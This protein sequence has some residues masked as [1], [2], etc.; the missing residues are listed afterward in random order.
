M[1]AGHDAIG[2]AVGLAGDH[3]KL[4]HGGFREGVQQFCSVFN[5]AAVLLLRAGKET[6]H[7]LE[8]DQGNIK[9]VA[10]THKSR[11][12]ERGVDVQHSGKHR[13]LVG[14][15][16]YGPAIQARE[17]DNQIFREMFV[18][19]KQVP[20]VRHGL[21]DVLHIV[22][23]PRIVGNDAVEFCRISKRTRRFAGGAARRVLQII[24]RQKAEQ[25]ANHG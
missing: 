4:R 8:S 7:V 13:G 19:F 20:V 18:H 5:D 2:S 21:D 11:A 1:F 22:G 16:P 25:L 23:H 12:L 9:S 3:R 14:D 10:K 24:R 6:G 15:D 17:P